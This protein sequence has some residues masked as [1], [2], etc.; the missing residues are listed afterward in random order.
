MDGLLWAV[1]ATHMPRKEKH[2][3]KHFLRKWRKF[4]GL[5]LEEVAADIGSTHATLSRVERGKLDYT[6]KLLEA[7]A[8]RYKVSVGDL[9]SRDPGEPMP[10]KAA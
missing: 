3:P 2:A 7:L 8:W 4:L 1:H 10:K 5:S 6:Q 9:L